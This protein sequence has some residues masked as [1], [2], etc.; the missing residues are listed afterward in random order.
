MSPKTERALRIGAW[1]LFYAVAITAL[2][3]FAPGEPQVFIYQE[4]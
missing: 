3:V 2:V 4:F 1:A